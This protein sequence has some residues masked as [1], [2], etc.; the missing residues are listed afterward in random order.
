[1]HEM[2][3]HTPSVQTRPEAQVRH[4]FP[5]KPQALFTVPARHTP[6]CTQPVQQL[7]A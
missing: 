2:I 3:S 7:P 1:M 6:L 4:V 5:P